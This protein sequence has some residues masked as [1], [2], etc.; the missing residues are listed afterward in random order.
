MAGELN[1]FYKL[2]KSEKPYIITS[3]LEKT[4]DSVNKLFSDAWE[5]ALKPPLPGKQLIWM[6]DASFRSVGY[7]LMTEDNP[8]QKI[9]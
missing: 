1:P 7:A 3:E 5:C 8:D 4:F 6:S 2:L 9:Q